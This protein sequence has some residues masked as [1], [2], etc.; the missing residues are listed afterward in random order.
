M[1]KINLLGNYRLLLILAIV[2]WSGAGWSQNKS[3]ELDS[4]LNHNSISLQQVLQSS[5]A[6]ASH[7]NQQEKL[8]NDN[9]PESRRWLA[10]PARIQLGLLNS[11][12]T[13]GTDETEISLNLPF[14]SNFALKINDQ[15]ISVNEKI[16]EIFDQ[17]LSLRLSG[18]IR[19]LVWEQKIAIAQQKY[20]NKKLSVLTQLEKN[21]EELFAA[22]ESSDYGLLVVQSEKNNTRIELLFNQ[23]EQ[24]RIL[25]KYQNI[26]GL[27]RFPM[28]IDE[29]ILR[30]KELSV[31]SHPSLKSLEHQWKQ[32]QLM[33]Q[34]QSGSAEPWYLSLIAK[35]QDSQSFSEDQVGISFEIPLTISERNNQSNQNNWLQAKQQ[36]ESDYQKTM[37][38]LQNR[39]D[40]NK[41]QEQ[42]L[43]DKSDILQNSVKLSRQIME[44]L[45]GLQAQN[46]IG[47]EV[48]LRRVLQALSI[49]NESDIL[50]ILLKK[51]NAMSRQVLGMTL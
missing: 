6:R 51:N 40:E 18:I 20:Y 5:F 28:V 42:Y 26:S 19:E 30:L 15:L 49:Q 43:L 47:Q 33:I 32:Q 8:T 31:L 23:K 29:P 21:S 50:K 36:F 46:E 35:K 7:N 44:K 27:N 14:N 12:E 22:G 4:S 34:S 16:V 17:L 38:T 37:M 13:S 39:L 48:V 2:V 25:K 9:S 45:D 41:I 11:Q 10:A 3:G 1:E 24:Q